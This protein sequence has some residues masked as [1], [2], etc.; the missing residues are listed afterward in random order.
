MATAKQ[1]GTQNVDFEAAARLV[2]ALEADLQKLSGSSAD[3]QRL[4]DEVAT[5]KN[6]L[7]SPVQRSHWVAEGLHGVR[8][9]FDRVKDEVVADGVKGGQYVAEI[10]RILGL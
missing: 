8:D 5:L 4:R 7:N 2:A 1:N 9:V 6:V 10:G 3:I